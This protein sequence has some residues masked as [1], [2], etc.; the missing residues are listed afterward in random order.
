MI[1]RH[2]LSPTIA[3]VLRSL[4]GRSTICKLRYSYMMRS[5]GTSRAVA[6]DL[7]NRQVSPGRAPHLIARRQ[8]DAARG[9]ERETVGAAFLGSSFLPAPTA[10]PAQPR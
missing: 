5:M 6:V 4:G 10:A 3:P 8:R 1:L 7:R 9:I 2:D